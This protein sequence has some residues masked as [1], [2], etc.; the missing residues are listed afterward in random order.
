VQI[1]G[2]L[3]LLA[4]SPLLIGAKVKLGNEVLVEHCFKELRGKRVALITN[5]SGVNR[6][7][8]AAPIR[9]ANC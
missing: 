8:P 4:S 9:H 1:L 7:P 3:V 6:N 5:A 2:V